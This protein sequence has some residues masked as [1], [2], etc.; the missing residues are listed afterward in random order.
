MLPP[1]IDCGEKFTGLAVVD[2]CR[3]DIIYA[4]SF[5]M[6]PDILDKLVLCALS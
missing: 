3:N 6:G 5:R 1:A 2:T 4:K